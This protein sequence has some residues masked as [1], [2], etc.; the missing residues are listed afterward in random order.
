MARITL[1]PIDEEQAASPFLQLDMDE[2]LLG[3]LGE[4]KFWLRLPI[5]LVDQLFLCLQAQGSGLRNA[6]TSSTN[7][8]L[9]TRLPSTI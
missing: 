1:T 3:G 2:G 4:R 6:K 5:G 9:F 7:M 8:L